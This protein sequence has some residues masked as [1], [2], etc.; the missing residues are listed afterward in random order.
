MDTGQRQSDENEDPE[1]ASSNGE[2]MD[3]DDVADGDG[4]DAENQIKDKE[5]RKL[6]P[7]PLFDVQV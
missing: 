4:A 6:K 7:G 2:D 1:I 3:L 5:I